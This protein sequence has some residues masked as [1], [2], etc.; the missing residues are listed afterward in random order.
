MYFR[1][2]TTSINKTSNNE[3]NNKTLKEDLKKKQ[4]H[5]DYVF[6]PYHQDFA[7]I[8]L[9]QSRR[10]VCHGAYKTYPKNTWSDQWDF[11]PLDLTLAPDWFF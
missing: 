2:Y 8:I 1:Q 7:H 6:S 10:T 4:P 3:N 5:R 11:S 9:S